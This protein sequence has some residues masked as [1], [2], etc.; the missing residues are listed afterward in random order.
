M[1]ENETEQKNESEI[2]EIMSTNSLLMYTHLL[3]LVERWSSDPEGLSTHISY[4]YP[5]YC[6]KVLIN[7]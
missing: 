1:R 5:G 3:N 2:I 7:E 4:K 6:N